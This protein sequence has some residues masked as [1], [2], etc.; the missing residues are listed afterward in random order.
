MYIAS[1]FWSKPHTVTASLPCMIVL[2]PFPITTTTW[3]PP[4]IT[5]STDTTTTTISPPPYSTEFVRISRTYIDR[6]Q[7]TKTIKPIPGPKPLCFKPSFQLFNIRICPPP[8]PDFPPPIPPITVIIPPPGIKP[9]PTAID[10]K[11]TEEEEGEEEEEEGHTC[12][13]GGNV[14]NDD[15]NSGD[16]PYD[17]SDSYPGA[18]E[19]NRP[20]DYTKEGAGIGTP[21]MTTES[22]QGRT[23]RVETVT[24]DD[25]QPS[26]RTLDP[27]PTQTTP[28]QP[29]KSEPT[30][31]TPKT[32]PADISCN[33]IIGFPR[34]DDISYSTT[35][36]F[37]RIAS[38]KYI[39]NAVGD[40][41]ENS[42]WSKNYYKSDKHAYIVYV[43]LDISKGYA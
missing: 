24:G 37:C 20:S 8:P 18:G 22:L 40:D 14:G 29:P 11:P 7:P 31:R 28:P 23:T 17:G 34:H 12:P 26:M 33:A 2:P 30:L 25:G 6:S 41:G 35:R 27:P 42:W 9:G 3:A 32:G 21:R 19:A 5:I 39:S 43:R 1:N 13:A 15:D 38:G 36:D 16:D 10:N 4:P